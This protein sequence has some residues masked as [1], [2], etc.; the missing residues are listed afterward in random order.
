MKTHGR[1]A[2]RART[3]RSSSLDITIVN[4]GI[5][6]PPEDEVLLGFILPYAPRR[7]YAA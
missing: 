3:G 6:E 7:Y 1:M 5:V 2:T 4:S